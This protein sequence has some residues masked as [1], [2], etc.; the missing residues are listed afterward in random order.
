MLTFETTKEINKKLLGDMCDSFMEDLKNVIMENRMEV[1]NMNCDWSRLYG[2]MI[3]GNEYYVD[4]KNQD[5]ANKKVKFLVSDIGVGDN[6]AENR[7]TN[8]LN[9]GKK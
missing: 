4:S 9:G 3:K 8:K 2:V 6:L 1:S 5:D 7:R